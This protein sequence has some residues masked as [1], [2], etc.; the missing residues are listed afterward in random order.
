[1]KKKYTKR[2]PSNKK[3]E[4]HKPS[5]IKDK[6]KDLELSFAWID[7]CEML[8]DGSNSEESTKDIEAIQK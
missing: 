4:V 2:A 1:M 5:Q 8:D 7:E 3:R 6:P